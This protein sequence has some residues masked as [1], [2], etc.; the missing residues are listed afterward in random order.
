MSL[1]HFFLK[2]QVL[3][4]ESDAVFPLRLSDDDLKHAR[5]LRL[6]AGEHVAVVDAASDYFECEVVSCGPDGVTA[7]I[8]SKLEA[9]QRPQVVLLQGIAKGEKMDQVVRHASELG[10]SGIVPLA[11][12]RSIVKLDAKKAASRTQRWRAIAKSAAMQAGLAAVPEVSEPLSV[13]K[14][15]EMLAGATAVL[16]FWEEAPLSAKIAPA[17]SAALSACDCP[18]PIDARVAVVI[19]PEGGLTP[20]E[21]AAFEEAND[22]THAVTL[23]PSILRT[24]TAGIV[25]PAL[26]LYELEGRA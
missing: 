3:A 2:E 16:V 15:A 22:R 14:A 8:A 17:L 7:C 19:G 1:Q 9:P 10:V 11:C 6:S 18:D 21:V 25:A 4:Q 24:E 23:G 12:D 5:V 20:R 26:V 13:R